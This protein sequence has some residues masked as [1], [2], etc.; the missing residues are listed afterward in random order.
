[1][2]LTTIVFVDFFVFVCHWQ[3]FLVL[4]NQ[5][6]TTIW[7]PSDLSIQ[8]P[9]VRGWKTDGWWVWFSQFVP[10]QTPNYYC[11]D[12]W[13]VLDVIADER[14]VSFFVVLSVCLVSRSIPTEHRNLLPCH[15]SEGKRRENEVV[16][17]LKIRKNWKYDLWSL[18]PSS[19]L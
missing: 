10:L 9:H 6:E 7:G 8:L 17:L 18:P 16:P 12:R 11:G 1:M 19:I 5:S 4:L 3:T 13:G 15:P 14:S 2:S